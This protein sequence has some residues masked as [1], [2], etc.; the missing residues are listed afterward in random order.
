[1]NELQ[2]LIDSY[3]VAGKSDSE[4]AELIM[5][6]EDAKTL[7]VKEVADLIIE[8]QNAK[9]VEEELKK[10]KKET[11]KK[12]AE[13]KAEK[14]KDEKFNKIIDEKL[15][16][17][18][19]DAF[20]KFA[21]A[22]ELKRFNHQT[23]M[24]ETIKNPSLAYGE[25][26]NM[27]KFFLD[28]D[29]KAAKDVSHQIDVDNFERKSL[30]L[31]RKIT[32]SDS[33]AAGGYAIPTEVDET[34]FQ[35]LYAA[36]EM[37]KI[38]NTENI[39]V[40]NKI[41]PL[42]YGID[43]SYIAD[44]ATSLNETNPTFSNPSVAMQ[45]VGA[46]SSISNTIIR[47]KGADLVQAFVAA[48]ASAYAKFFDLHIPCGNVSGNSDLVDGIIYDNNSFKLAAIALTALTDVKILDMI[49][50]LD[51]AV[52]LAKVYLTCNR[53]VTGRIGLLENS[54]G[55][56]LFPDFL[57][58]RNISPYGIPLKTNSRIPSTLDITGENR[59]TGTDDALICG[60]MSNVVVGISP[61]TRIDDS[62]HFL[63]TTDALVIR[64]IKRYGQKI[65][66]SASTAGKTVIVQKLTN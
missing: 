44:Q 6:H 24:F 8:R 7:T 55:N 30:N 5:Q 53:K 48:L 33:E 60:D 59:L 3:I 57:R 14:D 37:L 46:W 65:I 64:A 52:D 41:F 66:S 10:A 23:K 54:A 26:N 28:K 2:K 11:E 18:N 42:M 15:K 63:F 32:R 21:V 17:I 61:E 1:M 58:T 29:F 50:E 12:E 36:S 51:S 13:K 4:I 39:I 22:K 9:A 38:V 16:S 45:R 62:Q 43:V 35:L 19:Y 20:K 47:Q 56:K 31:G 40:E 49:N 34:I 27:L 25:F